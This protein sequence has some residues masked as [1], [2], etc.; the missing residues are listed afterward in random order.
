MNF[1]GTLLIEPKPQEPTKHQCVS[2]P[3]FLLPFSLIIGSPIY[4]PPVLGRDLWTS[5]LMN[6]F[7]L[8]GMIGMLQH[9]LI[10]WGNMV[11]LVSNYFV[12]S[13][14]SLTFSCFIL[15]E[16]VSLFPPY[17]ALN[18]MYL[19]YWTWSPFPSF[20]SCCRWF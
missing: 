11:L 4:T 8:S 14:N 20:L 5:M 1:V 7:I 19:Q 9:Q 12:F 16:K 3:Y 6:A 10:S 2:L 13:L 18:L 17:N 15:Y